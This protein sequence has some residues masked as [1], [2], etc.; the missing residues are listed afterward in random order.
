M[1]PT[2]SWSGLVAVVLALGVVAGIVILALSEY[3]SPEH[4]TGEEATLLSTVL[5]AAIGAVAA[6]LGAGHRI[7]RPDGETSAQ[8][9]AGGPQTAGP[10]PTGRP[11]GRET[12]AGP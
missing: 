4:V 11:D 7:G 12:P 8:N 3:F 9:G 2:F 10:V 5:G 1:R 6:Y